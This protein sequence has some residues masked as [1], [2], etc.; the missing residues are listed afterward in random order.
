ML[1]L[2]NCL[3]AGDINRKNRNG[4]NALHLAVTQSNSSI[5]EKL[6]QRGVNVNIPEEK[7]G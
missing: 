3:T 2:T 1:L 6:L 7:T 5:V 4:L